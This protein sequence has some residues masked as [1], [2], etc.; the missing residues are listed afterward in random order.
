MARVTEYRC[1]PELTDLV[2]R[3]STRCSG[4]AS[5]RALPAVYGRQAFKVGGRF[6]FWGGLTVEAAGG[7]PGLV[8]S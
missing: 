8:E 7:G 2:N 4:C 1:D 6:K 5:G 3:A